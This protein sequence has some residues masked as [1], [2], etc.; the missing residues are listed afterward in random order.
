MRKSD[1]PLRVRL[2]FLFS[3]IVTIGIGGVLLV[4]GW[5]LRDLYR[6]GEVRGQLTTVFN[7]L[8]DDHGLPRSFFVIESLSCPDERC[9]LDLTEQPN[10]VTAHAPLQRIRV[11]WLR[12]EPNAYTWAYVTNH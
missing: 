2:F 11:V 8:R 5:N 1:M 7:G 6:S 3:F 4:R 12:T 10:L 9:T